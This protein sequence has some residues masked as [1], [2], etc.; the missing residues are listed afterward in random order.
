MERN[1]EHDSRR[2]TTTLEIYIDFKNDLTI[3]AHQVNDLVIYSVQNEE[4][5]HSNVKNV[6]LFNELIENGNWKRFTNF[7][8]NSYNT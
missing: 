2:M 5:L 3:I 4:V 8:N 7:D 1:I 6:S